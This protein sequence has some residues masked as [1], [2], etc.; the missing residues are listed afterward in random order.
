KKVKS[1]VSSDQSLELGK[2][3]DHLN[4]INKRVDARENFINKLDKDL[5]R[6]LSDFEINILHDRL[7]EAH[8]NADLPSTLNS[9]LKHELTV[10]RNEINQLRDE[11]STKVSKAESELIKLAYVAELDRY[12]KRKAT[13]LKKS[14][15]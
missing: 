4:E 13:S 11:F 7:A 1:T 10:V 6:A 3:I 5:A 9:H 14:K 2:I 12:L 8:I 15:S